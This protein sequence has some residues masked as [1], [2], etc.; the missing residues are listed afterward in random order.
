M[1]RRPR[2]EREELRGP[3]AIVVTDPTLYTMACTNRALGLSKMTIEVFRDFDEADAW[4]NDSRPDQRPLTRAADK[5]ASVNPQEPL[6]LA[7]VSFPASSGCRSS[8][9]SG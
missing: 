4:L 3:I 7:I 1:S 2:G 6:M 5:V 8:S 9:G